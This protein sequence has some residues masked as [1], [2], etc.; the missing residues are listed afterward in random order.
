[1]IKNWIQ[2]GNFEHGQPEG[3]TNIGRP[4]TKKCSD[5][6]CMSRRYVYPYASTLA[7]RPCDFASATPQYFGLCVICAPLNAFLN[8]FAAF[9]Q[10]KFA[11][12]YPT[13]VA[14]RGRSQGRCKKSHGLSGLNRADQARHDDV[15]SR[16]HSSPLPCRPSAFA[17]LVPPWLVS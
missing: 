1:M 2:K 12:L 14:L 13:L 17:W 9:G 4:G 5:V 7:S 6:A 16:G 10:V 8:R 11:K 15:F 3:T